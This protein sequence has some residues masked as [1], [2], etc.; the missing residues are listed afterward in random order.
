MCY[1]RGQIL[2]TLKENPHQRL[3]PNKQQRLEETVPKKSIRLRS[4]ASETSTKYLQRMKGGKIKARQ[5][6]LSLIPGSETTQLRTQND[7]VTLT[8]PTEYP[9]IKHQASPVL[10]GEADVG[11]GLHTHTHTHT[12][13]HNPI[14]LLQKER[15]T[16]H[17]LTVSENLIS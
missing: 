6:K 5:G 11:V 2:K 1:K 3:G 10:P 8:T 14:S 16:D 9:S 17:G 13:T 12:H 15:P 7:Y 4:N